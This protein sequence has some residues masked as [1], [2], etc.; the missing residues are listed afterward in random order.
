MC[1]YTKFSVS[2]LKKKSV[3]FL[4]FS[5]SCW[6]EYG[7]PGWSLAATLD[8]ELEVTCEEWQNN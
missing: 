4:S 2:V 6:L 3:F 5:P 8:H 7:P 1:V